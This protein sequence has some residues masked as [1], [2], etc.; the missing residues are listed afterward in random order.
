MPC[1]W[2]FAFLLPIAWYV[3]I[4]F[5]MVIQIKLLNK[6]TSLI[7]VKNLDEIMLDWNQTFFYE[8]YS[9]DESENCQRNSFDRLI[10]SMA[11]D[12][13]MHTCESSPG[14]YSTGETGGTCER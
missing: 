7:Y 12:G 9:V 5:L 3:A 1:N 10:L 2:F 11:W 14:D 4:C 13:A 6:D 8:I